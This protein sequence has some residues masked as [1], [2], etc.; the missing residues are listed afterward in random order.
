MHSIY[1]GSL[2]LVVCR[3]GQLTLT[4]SHW[5]EKPGDTP[6]RLITLRPTTVLIEMVSFFFSLGSL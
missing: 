2:F 1:V 5:E 6:Q 3:E 4:I